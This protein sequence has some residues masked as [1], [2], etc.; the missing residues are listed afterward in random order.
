MPVCKNCGNIYSKWR[1]LVSLNQVCAK[2]EPEWN[3]KLEEEEK[4]KKKTEENEAKAK[5]ISIISKHTEGDEV[6]AYGLGY[7]DTAGSRVTTGVDKLVGA[8]LLGGWGTMLATVHHQLGIVA[9]TRTHLHLI[10]LNNISGTEIR[11]TDILS[12][13]ETVTSKSFGL[14]EISVRHHPSTPTLI[15]TGPL[16]VNVT[17]PTILELDNNGKSEL[18]HEAIKNKR[19]PA[20][21]VA[22]DSTIKDHKFCGNCGTRI[23]VDAKFCTECGIKVIF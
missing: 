16:R 12:V 22:A 18:I 6:L 11:V 2:C 7:W 1:S 17:F 3:K 10:I 4:I 19:D 23:D 20:P 14:T 15:I 5:I 8:A 21:K 13:S 9:I